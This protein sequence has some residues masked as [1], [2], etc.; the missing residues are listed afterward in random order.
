MGKEVIQYIETSYDTVFYL[1]RDQVANPTH[2]GTRQ[3]RLGKAAMPPMR[4]C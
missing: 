2:G 4:Q 1:I 3:A